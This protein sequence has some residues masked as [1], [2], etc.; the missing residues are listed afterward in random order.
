MHPL[1]TLDILTAHLGFGHNFVHF[2]KYNCVSKFSNFVFSSWIS[3]IV[4]LNFESKSIRLILHRLNGWTCSLQS[5]QNW[6]SQCWHLPV[7]SDFSMLA[8]EPQPY[9]GHQPTSSIYAMALLRESCSYLSLSDLDSPMFLMSQS[10]ISLLHP[11]SGQVILAT[12]PSSILPNTSSLRHS[13]QYICS[14]PERKKN[15]FP[16]KF[17]LHMPQ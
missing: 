7:F 6:N 10:F 13:E 15:L 11:A 4:P 9:T 17:R 12:V 2:F 1:L 14:Q 3:V 8:T 5:R 16:N